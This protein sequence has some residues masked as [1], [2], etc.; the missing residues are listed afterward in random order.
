MFQPFLFYIDLILTILLVASCVLAYAVYLIRQDKMYFYAALFQLLCLFIEVSIHGAEEESFLTN[1]MINNFGTSS[2]LLSICYFCCSV[3]TVLFVADC[4][5]F[6]ISIISFI[7]SAFLL[8]WF[9][10]LLLMNVS[11]LHIWLFIMP[12]QLFTAGISI[13]ALVRLRKYGST[14][15]PL[16]R[17]FQITVLFSCL[18]FAEDTIMAFVN[19]FE[20]KRNFTENVL[21]V[22]Y[23]FY[24]LVSTYDIFHSY[25]AAPFIVPEHPLV[26]FEQNNSAYLNRINT[27]ADSLQLTYRERELLPM[28]LE[29]KSYQEISEAF[30]IS[31]GTVKVHCHNIY[32]KA[33]VATRADLLQRYSAFQ[34]DNNSIG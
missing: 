25:K 31:V 32:S 20:T 2:V 19:R 33:D 8:I 5:G 11:L 28:L 29:K 23:S 30:F 13:Y 6:K 34:S 1:F 3:I 24:I 21:W 18:I 7:P 16:L 22:I 4:T 10:F 26:S 12:Y 14:D 17:L 9:V 27:F 15:K